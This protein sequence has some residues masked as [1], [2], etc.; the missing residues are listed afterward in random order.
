MRYA[1]FLAFQGW[2]QLV[3]RIVLLGALLFIASQV[4]PEEFGSLQVAIVFFSLALT[5]NDA[6]F[7]PQI[8]NLVTPRQHIP[9]VLISVKIYW[10]L[11]ATVAMFIVFSI[12]YGDAS[13]GLRFL[14]LIAAL[15]V[16]LC[17]FFLVC[18]RGLVLHHIEAAFASVQRIGAALLASTLVVALGEVSAYFIAMAITAALVLAL[19]WRSLTKGGLVSNA[20]LVMR[21][22]PVGYLLLIEVGTW[23]YSR[24]DLIILEHWHGEATA[25]QYGL[26]YTVFSGLAV[27]SVVLVAVMY[28]EVVSRT[29]GSRARAIKISCFAL[30]IVGAAVTGMVMTVGDRVISIVAGGEFQSA[31]EF[32]VLLAPGYLAMFPNALLSQVAILR[33]RTRELSL[34]IV[35]VACGNAVANY[36]FVPDYGAAAA[37]WITVATEFFLVGFSLILVGAMAATSVPNER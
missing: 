16:S 21:R 36:V 29:G 13:L 15:L 26:A 8:I 20:P 4:G 6:G 9:R 2:H 5:V 27:T 24:I 34:V 19:I 12:A 3:G 30:S 28:P 14:V 32:L 1:I 35:F 18:L 17:S 23:V 31:G 7:A 37:V 25:G 11:F 22:F 33:G 10:S